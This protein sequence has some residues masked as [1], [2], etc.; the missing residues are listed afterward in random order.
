MWPLLDLVALEH[1]QALLVVRR[2]QCE[3]VRVWPKMSI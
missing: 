2:V 1:P 3:S